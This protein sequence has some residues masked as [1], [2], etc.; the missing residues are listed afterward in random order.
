VHLVCFVVNNFLAGQGF[1]N[2]NIF[3]LCVL[4]GLCGS[5]SFLGMWGGGH[6]K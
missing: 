2:I 1:N 4:C 5:I 6:L 3:F